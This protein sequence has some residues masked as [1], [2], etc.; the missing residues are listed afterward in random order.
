MPDSALFPE[1]SADEEV[2]SGSIEKVVFHSEETGFCVLRVRARGHRDVET[3][4]GRVASISPGEWIK[5]A[6]RWVND[7]SHGLQFES[8]YMN[9]SEPDSA[10]GLEKYLASG[11]I[12]GIGRV[13][14]KKLVA[15]FGAEVFDVIENQKERLRE[16]PGIGPKRA[17]RIIRAWERQKPV[18][19]IMLFLRSHRIGAAR[20][21]KIHKLYGAGALRV[22][23]ENPYRLARDIRGVGFAV[24]D[25]IADQVG[26]RKD[27]SV[28]VR[29]GISHA[30][31][32]ATKDGHCA[33]PRDELIGLGR[34]LL[35]VPA[36][37]VEKALE[38][39]IE[40][41][42]VVPDRIGTTACVFL[43]YLHRAERGVAKAL[44]RLL[45]GRVPWPSINPE[46]ALPWAERQLGLELAP[47]Q[48]GAVRAALGSKVM[49]ITGG[50]GV[51]K[52]TIVNA[53]LRVLAAKRIRIELA[54]PTGRAAKRL[55][56]TT[57]M[58]ARTIH[59]LL[60]FDPIS[61]GFRRDKANPLDCDV[62]VIDETSMVDLPLMDSVLKALPPKAGLLLVGDVDQLP[63]VGPG[64]VLADLIGSGALPVARLVEVFRQ[65]AKS[66]IVVNAHRV[67]RGEMPDMARPQGETDFYFV[68]ADSPETAIRRTV[69]MVRSRIPNRF[70]FDPA[71]EI[72]V[73]CP[74][75]RGGIG[76]K[77]LNGELQ[78]ALNPGSGDRLER[79]GW[80]FCRGD[81]VMQLENDYDKEVYNGDIG[82]IAVLDSERGELT[83]DFD[84]RHV[85]YSLR[86]ID[87]LAPAY[88]ITIHKSQ[89]SEYPA[90]VIPVMNSHFVMLQRNL[91][92][93]GLTRGRRLVV[94]L[95]QPAAIRRA[96]RSASTSQ[97]WS[98]LRERIRAAVEPPSP[99]AGRHRSE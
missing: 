28:R 34:D 78:D 11:A 56:E 20:A 19:E 85:P 6:G 65:A 26:I 36:E 82:F 1:L 23:S 15:A 12:P 87:A 54:A 92:Y 80:S 13:Y 5:A 86:E 46:R 33:L 50:P 89:G 63:S 9:V 97:R 32:E 29:A 81:K 44:G 8:T 17:R 52:T 84:G 73:L 60:E 75:N 27:A 3:V 49:V 51:G 68:A 31:A 57:Y 64:Q 79:R 98:K 99:R 30:L 40:I 72:Q 55:S 2:L 90:V 83:V 14:A 88:A 91:L 66:R 37:V 10:E 38:A 69:E 58:E 61:G 76:T 18:R 24:A 47:S 21:Q 35:G 59:R 45:R 16:V 94:L 70:G 22:L 39:E 77:V 25:G 48:A 74:M 95:G 53:I 7:R 96:V 41:G 71:R 62:L 93:T 67:N 4:V 43:P 42:N